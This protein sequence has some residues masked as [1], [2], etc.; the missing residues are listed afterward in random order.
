M[1]SIRQLWRQLFSEHKNGIVVLNTAK[2]WLNVF[3]ALGAFTHILIIAAMVIDILA[4]IIGIPAILAY[5]IAVLHLMAWRAQKDRK[6]EHLKGSLQ[7]SA[8]SVGRGSSIGA[9]LSSSFLSKVGQRG[10]DER[11]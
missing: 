8:Q 7:S 4:A 6:A 9:S 11:G 10:D 2:F 3:A 5:N 1:N